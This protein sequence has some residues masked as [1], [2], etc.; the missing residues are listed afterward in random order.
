MSSLPQDFKQMSQLRISWL[1]WVMTHT[2]TG[3]AIYSRFYQPTPHEPDPSCGTFG[4]GLW[5][6]SLYHHTDKTH[7]IMSQEKALANF[8]P[9]TSV[10]LDVEQQI[11]MS[12]ESQNKWLS[13]GRNTMSLLVL[14][15]KT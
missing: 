7:M 13:P 14:H 12:V 1:P 3:V 6:P 2:K 8:I 5:V 15:L 10:L 11:H 9:H 4:S